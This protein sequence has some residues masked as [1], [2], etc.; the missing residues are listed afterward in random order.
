MK[1]FSH[2][3][4][5]GFS[6]TYI[7]GPDKGGDAILVDPGVMDLES[8][9]LIEGNNFYVRHILVTTPH[10]SHVQGLKTTLKIYEAEV[11]SG[12]TM[13]GDFPCT[14]VHDGEQLKLAGFEVSVLNVSG[15]SKD[16]MVYRVED[17]LFTG[18]ALGAGR[19]GDS[20][21]ADARAIL[22]STILEKFSGLDD[23]LLVFPGHG[24]PSTLAAE[25]MFN[26]AFIENTQS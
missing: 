12:L 24:P 14:Q 11:Y 21:N 19:L 8:L 4:V 5:I 22:K 7:V 6:N 20:P 10:E 23:H 13:I 1:L 15:H 26:P 9:K 16:S 17:V 2:F 3:A 25:K 18:D